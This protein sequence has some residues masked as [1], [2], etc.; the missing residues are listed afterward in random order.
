MMT[1]PSH[2]LEEELAAAE[3]A[4]RVAQ[5]MPA[6]AA[7]IEALRKAGQMRFDAFKKLDVEHIDVRFLRR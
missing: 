6:G 2:Q 7:R 4:L 5:N 3:D 1:N